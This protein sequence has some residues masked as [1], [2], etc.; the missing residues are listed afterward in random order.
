MVIITWTT[1]VILQLIH[2]PKTD[3]S[4]RTHLPR[5]I[6]SFWD[7]ALCNKNES[8]AHG[9]TLSSTTSRTTPSWRSGMRTPCRRQASLDMLQVLK[10]RRMSR[11]SLAPAF[12]VR[13]FR[14]APETFL[15]D[16]VMSRNGL[17]SLGPGI[18]FT[19]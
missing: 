18:S 17:G 9:R 1:E 3:F 10:L 14:S 7:G 13:C 12:R 15:S 8:S 16:C 5:R 2:A 4:E 6:V 19:F 11:T